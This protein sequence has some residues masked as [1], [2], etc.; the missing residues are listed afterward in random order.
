[1]KPL[2]ALGLSF[3]SLGSYLLLSFSPIQAEEFTGFKSPTGNIFCMIFEGTLRCD[4]L[5][6]DAKLPPHP[7][8]CDLDWGNAF[9]VGQQNQKAER[10]CAG[11][12]VANPRYPVL[13]YG[14]SISKEGFTCRSERTGMTCK[15][16][17]GRGFFLSR[18]KQT[19]L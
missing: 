4:L 17:F 2:L 7:K 18:Q 10:V 12:S 9:G 8:D 5:Q 13:N 16:K 19:L 15:N 6:N 14:K 11:D 3:L 1:M